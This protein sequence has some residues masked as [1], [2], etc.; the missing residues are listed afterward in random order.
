M[1]APLLLKS[2][3]YKGQKQL[4]AYS[5]KPNK[6]KSVAKPTTVGE[7]RKAEQT[8]KDRETVDF[9]PE[10]QWE[11]R[12]MHRP[13]V[14]VDIQLSWDSFCH[15]SNARGL[16][17]L[18]SQGTMRDQHIKEISG[19]WIWMHFYS[20]TSTQKPTWPT[21]QHRAKAGL[22]QRRELLDWDRRWPENCHSSFGI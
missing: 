9:K 14:R 12:N 10:L 1:N 6:V 2:Q 11:R 21:E 19:L 15:S 4:I 17:R 16:H 22:K 13:G 20:H 8:G 5:K 3:H 7:E 18:E